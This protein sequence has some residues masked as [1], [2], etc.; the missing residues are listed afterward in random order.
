M[1]N[2]KKKRTRA[3]PYEV[4]EMNGGKVQKLNGQRKES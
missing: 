1:I 4:I 2:R 3:S